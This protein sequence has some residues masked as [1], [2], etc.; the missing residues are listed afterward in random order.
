MSWFGRKRDV[1]EM[2]ILGW[3]HNIGAIDEGR[4]MSV[5]EISS[6]I[7]MEISLVSRHLEELVTR[8]YIAKKT[9]LEEK[10]FV[11][12]QGILRVVKAYT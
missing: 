4:A 2:T 9:D 7:D 11:K 8:G 3:L 12:P 5:E 1:D 6:R 10:F